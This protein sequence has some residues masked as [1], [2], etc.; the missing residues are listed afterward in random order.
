MKARTQTDGRRNLEIVYRKKKGV[1][2]VASLELTLHMH[3]HSTGAL[4]SP[5]KNNV[6]CLYQFSGENNNNSKRQYPEKDFAAQENTQQ[7]LS[8]CVACLVSSVKREEKKRERKDES[9][10]K[11]ADD[12]LA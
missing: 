8:L 7:V 11:E 5:P 2:G 1:D 9:G 4:E 6:V 3:V 10:R 12:M